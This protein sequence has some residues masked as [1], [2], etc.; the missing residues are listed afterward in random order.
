[1]GLT[2]NFAGRWI[3]KEDLQHAVLKL[4]LE[5]FLIGQRQQRSLRLFK[6]VVGLEPEVLVGECLVHRSVGVAETLR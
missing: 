2:T 5:V 6:R 4:D 3:F 1:L